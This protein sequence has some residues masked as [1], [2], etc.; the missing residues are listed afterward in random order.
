MQEKWNFVTHREGEMDAIFLFFYAFGLYLSGIISDLFDA[1]KV[2]FIGLFC[3]S[4]ILI[5]FASLIPYFN[6]NNFTIFIIIWSLNGLFQS[7]GWPT[8]V[9]LVANWFNG[10]HNGTLFGIWASNQ[11]IGN[12]IGALYVSIVHKYNWN[13][14]WMFYMPSIQ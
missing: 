10:K 6:I 13:I 11:C 8:S 7:T 12:I 4:L 1:K 5:L 2:H 9:K 3:T 14:Q